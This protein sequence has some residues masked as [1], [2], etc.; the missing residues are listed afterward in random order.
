MSINRV[1]FTFI[2]HV[3]CGEAYD[4]FID[5][6]GIISCSVAFSSNDCNVN[7]SEMSTGL[8]QS[9][10]LV[11]FR[12]CACGLSGSHVRLKLQT[13]LSTRRRS[14]VIILLSITVIVVLRDSREYAIS[15]FRVENRVE[16]SC[17]VPRI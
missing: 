11:S 15:E 7:N 2:T 10:P 6:Q 8:L 16:S 3:M 12:E 9:I 17:Y 5:R 1:P 13:C 14:I 4:C